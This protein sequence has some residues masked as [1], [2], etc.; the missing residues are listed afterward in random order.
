M[1]NT[2]RYVKQAFTQ[3]GTAGGIVTVATTYRFVRGATVFLSSNTQ[4]I[5]ELQISEVISQTKIAVKIANGLSY[6]LFDCSAYTTA[7]SAA[8]TQPADANKTDNTEEVVQPVSIA[9]VPLPDG[10]ATETTLQSIDTEVTAINTKTPSLGQ[11]T[12]SGST[13]VVLAADQTPILTIPDG[14]VQDPSNSSITPLGI[15]GTFTGSAKDILQYAQVMVNVEADRAGTLYIEFSGDQ[16]IW[17]HIISYPVLAGE[18][19]DI[20]VA[21]HARYFRVSFTNTS[22]L[23][24]TYF[25]LYSILRPTPSGMNMVAID[26]LIT[27]H[28]IAALTKGVIM[29]KTTGGGGGY[30]DVKVTPSGALTVDA[31]IGSLPLPTNAATETTLSSIN[32]KIPALGQAAMVASLPVTVAND[33]TT[34]PTKELV[35]SISTVSSV[36]GS[37]TSVTLLA[38]NAGR[39]S[40][41]IHNE[42]NAVLY[43]KFGT[44][45]SSS[46]Y[47]YRIPA[48]ATWEMTPQRYTGIITGAWSNATGNARITELT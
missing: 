4:S 1:L 2:I 40:A 10:A 42:S 27:G 31:S 34:L 33:Q 13:P 21:P 24:Q 12:M 14:V 32:T 23:A 45:A 30:V 15:G 17:G 35:S 25:H 46:S 5:V 29:G 16:T 41:V 11:T 37:V 3:N 28:N 48:N 39:L 18:S 26:Q 7:D 8:I 9:Y 44:S 36:A 6:D 20:A 43:L 22:G 38:A 47:T 19:F